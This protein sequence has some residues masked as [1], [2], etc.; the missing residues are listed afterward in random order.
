MIRF[1]HVV[2]RL[3][4]RNVLDDLSFEVKKGEVFVI[5]GPSGTGKSVTLKHMVQ[6]L[7]PRPARCGWTMWP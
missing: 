5:V 2:K 6:L 1:E 7:R 4:G 3:A